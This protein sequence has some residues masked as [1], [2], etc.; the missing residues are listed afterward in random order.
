MLV[1]TACLGWSQ[2]PA[3]DSASG[4]APDERQCL[5]AALPL[6]QQHNLGAAEA[7][8]AECQRE[9]PQS[10][11]LNNAL[12]IV[13]EQEG[14]KQE[15]TKAF[16]RALELLP[17]FTAAQIHLGTLY[18]GAGNCGP[19]QRLLS[20]AASGTSDSGAL[21]ASGVGLAQ[22]HDLPGSI[23]VLEKR[24]DRIQDPTLRASIWP[25]PDTRTTSFQAVFNS[26]TLFPVSLTSCF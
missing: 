12:G 21:V 5:A 14:R 1:C 24:C 8:L 10:A 6:L 25:S 13:Y 15:A 16:E 20:A 9:R 7:K 23:Q 19:A 22:C 17:S 26:S 18:A 2:T 4:L 3:G 11:I